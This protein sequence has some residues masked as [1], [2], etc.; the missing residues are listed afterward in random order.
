MRR[1]VLGMSLSL[2]ISF[3]ACLLFTDIN[4]CLIAGSNQC[5]Q[6]CHNTVGSYTCSCRDGYSLDSNRFGCSGRHMHILTNK[7]THARATHNHYNPIQML[8]NVLL[9]LTNALTTAV[10]R[11]A[12]TLAAAELGTHSIVMALDA[13]VS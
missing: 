9:T 3:H 13:L 5:N 7:C 2:L 11:L 8:M 12:H 4:E 6:N 10:T 1:S